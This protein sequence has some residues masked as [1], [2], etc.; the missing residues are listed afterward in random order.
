MIYQRGAEKLLKDAAKQFC[1]ITFYGARQVGKTT[2]VR[3]AFGE[4]MPIVSL[5]DSQE[6]Y[7]A[8][9][10]PKLFLDTHPW[11]VIIDEIQ[12]A[13]NL[14]S[15]IKIKIDECKY[16]WLMNNE[17]NQ[18]MY[19]LTGSNQFELQKATVE[20]LAGRTAVINMSSLSLDEKDRNIGGL[21]NPE[22]RNRIQLFEEIFQGGMP[23]YVRLNP[24]R[25]LF[26]RSYIDKYIERDV[27]HLIAT[28]SEFQFRN[29][30]SLVALR[31]AQEIIWDDLSK[32]VGIDVKTCK[33]WIS[34]LETSGLVYMLHPY[35][36]NASTTIIK[37][38]K[39]YFL[40]TG[41][42]AY[43]C[44]WPNAEMLEKGIMAR[45]FF[46]TFVVSEIVKS[47]YKRGQDP[48][49]ELF[50]FRSITRIE[51]DLLLVKQ[52]EIYP[53]EIKKGIAPSNPTK[54]FSAL[55]IYK[56]TIK[57]GLVIDSCEKLFP[58]NNNAWYCPVSLISV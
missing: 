27:K 45:A 15:Y 16:T 21:F 14:L 7:L 24:D 19:V 53:I 51:V 2:A 3:L 50:Y 33:R 56:K 48:S 25:D 8:K 1:C 49:S 43:L 38:P 41:L 23:E 52:D 6:L 31:T 17:P 37:A 4:S 18:L 54:N 28:G 42:C 13:P 39:L 9:V 20:S 44:K 5:D 58:V 40:D 30:L 57:T 32:S 35:M 12:K 55:E 34:I 10:N 47:Y 26:F 46:E 36:K 11:P 29:F 22:P